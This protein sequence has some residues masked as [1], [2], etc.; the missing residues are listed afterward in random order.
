MARQAALLST[1]LLLALLVPGISAA[2]NITSGNSTFDQNANALFSSASSIEWAPGLVATISLIGGVVVTFFGYKLFRPVMF[3]CGFAVGSVLGYLLAE[4]IFSG[5]SYVVTA[6]WIAFLV[7]GLLVGSIVM[8][9]WVCGVFLV[10]AA[11]GVLLAFELNTSVGYKIYPSN[12]TTSLWIL[13]IVLGLLA[14]GLAI[15]LERPMLIVSTSMFGAIAATWGVGYFAG[16]YP[17]GA[18][19]DAW[20]KQAADGTFEYNL[21]KAWWA[22]LAA[23]ALLFGLGVYVQFHKTA[24]GI[25]HSNP[26]RKD[27][28]ATSGPPRGQPISH[29]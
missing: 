5:Q 28:V 11:A 9:L 15:W 3:I 24:A 16:Q 27:A 7:L 17:S 19:L 13:I 2:A 26:R 29:V 4:Q 20:R 22:Y 6:S 25:V 23:T 14:G 21:P 12:P 10:G 18:E 1:F 8:N